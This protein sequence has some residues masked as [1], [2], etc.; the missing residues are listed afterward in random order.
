MPEMYGDLVAIR[1][2]KSAKRMN[3]LIRI[4]STMRAYGS[5]DDFF[6][7]RR[8]DKYIVFNE[9]VGFHCLCVFLGVLF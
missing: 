8:V 3:R 4:V 9:G 5:S 1:H 2:L 7:H 6:L